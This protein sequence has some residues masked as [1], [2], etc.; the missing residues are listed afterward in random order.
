MADAGRGWTL[1]MRDLVGRSGLGRHAI[2][3]YIQQ[4]LLPPGHKTG[5]N[6]ARY[7][8]E[9][10]KRL[11]LVQR[12][13]KEAFLPLRAIKAIFEGLEGADDFTEDQMDFL[14]SV[15]DGYEAPETAAPIRTVRELV[16]SGVIGRTDLDRLI[17]TR[18]V[19][20]RM[21]EGKLAIVADDLWLVEVV[22]ELREAGIDAGLQISVDDLAVY[23]AAI[24][25]LIVAET[26]LIAKRMRHLP[27][28]DVVAR[29][30]TA[31][32]LIHK[33]MNKR[34]EARLREMMRNL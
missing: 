9:H 28:G 33:L 1:K 22:G 2:H 13:R 29:L 19:R 10:L 24:D 7:G 8:P 6:T 23:E 16:S 3:F 26:A 30:E 34:H 18:R 12:L 11:E 27:P 20:T 17:E 25:R 15:K 32:P 4:G 21:H 5:R 14:R 31:L